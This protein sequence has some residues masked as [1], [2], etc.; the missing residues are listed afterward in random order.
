MYQ[1]YNY[2]MGQYQAMPGNDPKSFCQTLTQEQADALRQHIEK[3]T[4]NLSDK[5]IWTAICVHRDPATGNTTLQK[6]A[7]DPERVR[8]ALCGESFRF[9]R[10][11]SEDKVQMLID[12]ALDV[13]QSIKAMYMDMPVDSAKNF[14]AIIAL[15]KKVPGV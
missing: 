8:C 13:M 4:L 6:D 1:P 3:F 5:D 10:N 11:L 15:L 12:Q 9:L 7:L 14:F 2:G